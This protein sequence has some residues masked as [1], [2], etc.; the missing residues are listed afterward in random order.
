MAE[1]NYQTQKYT[2]INLSTS[3]VIS[4]FDELKNVWEEK[5]TA[6]AEGGLLALS[7]FEH[8][9]LL[10][11]LRLVRRWR[12]A[13]EADRKNSDV[14]KTVVTEAIS[15]I[16]ESGLLVTLTQV[17]QTLSKT[18]IG[19]ALEELWEI[20][21]LALLHTPDLVEH[22]YFVVSGKFEDSDE[23]DPGKAIDGWGTRKYKDQ[24]QLLEKFKSHVRW[25][26]VPNPKE[27]LTTELEALGRD[28]DTKTIISRWLGYL[29]QLG[30]GLSPEAASTL[31]WRELT[32]DASLKAF[33]TT[34]ARIFSRSQYLLQTIRYAIAGH[35]KLS[36]TDELSQLQDL[37][38]SN[39]I[40]LLSGS[41]GSGK[42]ALC[43]IGIQE[44][45]QDYTCLFLSPDDIAIFEDNSEAVLSKDLRRFDELLTARIIN[46]TIVFVDDV[47]EANEQSLDSLLNLL[48]NTIST[49]TLTNVRFVFVTHPDT[50]Q[51]IQEQ[52]AARFD[53]QPS[54]GMV[55][56]PQLPLEELSSINNLPHSITELIKRAEQFGSAFNFKL[57]D[58]L[59]RKA[60]KEDID[61]SS[62]QTDLD[63][64]NWFWCNQVGNGREV[65]QAHRTLIEI[66]QFLAEKFAPD[67][68]VY[69]C[70]IDPKT[71]PILARRECLRVAEG[72]IALTHRFVGDCA[73][74]HYLL[75]KKRELETED[76][77]EMQS[78]I[79]WSQ[80]MRWFA[81]YIALESDETEIWQEFLQEAIESEHNQ[82]IK[83][84]ID[85][86]ILSGRVKILLDS[87]SKEQFPFL[88]E[89]LCSRLLAIA[90]LPHFEY[91]EIVKN[92]SPG[93]R[94]AFLEENPGTP[95]AHLWIPAWQWILSLEMKILASKNCLVFK[96]AEAWLN[97]GQSAKRLPQRVEIAKFILKLAKY[98]L[99]PDTDREERLWLGDSS[100]AYKCIVFSLMHIPEDASWLLKALAG[101]ELT[102]KTQLAPTT[103]H[104]MF[105]D[106]IGT[107]EF[108]HPKGA[109]GEVN[110]SFRKFMLSNH[111]LYLNGV[112]RVI[113]EL[114]AEILLALTITPPG[115]RFP[116]DKDYSIMNNLGT[117]GSL[118]IDLCT[119]KFLPLLS[120][121][122]NSEE[123]GIEVVST[124][125]QVANN[126]WQ[127][128]CWQKNRTKGTPKTDTNKVEL[129]IDNHR[130]CFQGGRH[131]LYWH[132]KYPWSPNILA[133]FLMTLEGWLYERP[134][135]YSLERSIEL[136]FKKAD[137]VAM[138]GVL[139][140]LAKK[141]MHL[142]TSSLLPLI[143]SLQLLI[144]YE[145]EEIDGGQNYGFDDTRAYSKLLEKE[146]QEL[147]DFHRLPH[148]KES[149]LIIVLHFLVN[150]LFET[151]VIDSIVKDWD[152]YQLN[153]IPEC[154]RSRGLKLRKQFEL[155]NW[156]EEKNAQG[157]PFFRFIGTLPE[158]PKVDKEAESARWKLSQMNFV[159]KC[160]QILDGRLSIEEVSR[161]EL[162]NLLTNEKELS[163]LEEHL[164]EKAFKETI[165]AALALI[166][167]FYDDTQNQQ[168]DEVYK[169]AA[170]DFS[171]FPVSLNYHDRS[172]T[173]DLDICTFM[174]Y[175]APKLLP[176]IEDEN[177]RFKTIF[178]CLIGIKN[179][180]TRIFMNSL[181]KEYGLSNSICH[182]TIQVIPIIAR[183]ISLTRALS[184]TKNKSEIEGKTICFCT[185]H[186]KL[187]LENLV[188][189]LAFL[190]Y[191]QKWYDPI[192]EAWLLLEQQFSEDT[193][194]EVN[195][196]DIFTWTPSNLEPFYQEIPK[197]LKDNID[198]DFLVA[199]F[200]PLIEVVP[201]ENDDKSL[202]LTNEIRENIFLVLLHERARLYEHCRY[203]VTDKNRKC[204]YN[205]KV[206]YQSQEALISALIGYS[207]KVIVSRI[208]HLFSLIK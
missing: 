50:E 177:N 64:L 68:A 135:A 66:S 158:D 122:N 38:L 159:V 11:L 155:S 60:Q 17:K 124:L 113:P 78:N 57:L 10:T 166:L 72:R 59:V 150:G 174:S 39:R 74:F 86:A 110:N 102:P 70:D 198:W 5:Q 2:S 195:I 96:I 162:V 163:S 77:A 53:K 100:A 115:Y 170:E 182:R 189:P 20:F 187:C 119:F 185:L 85:G 203:L 45:F 4:Q 1:A 35:F 157:T 121:L 95:R 49:D 33:Q 130:K 41:S 179:S 106:I 19:K 36:R 56:L 61:T 37:V 65:N 151:K 27:D 58:W 18:A 138:L 84:L 91:A 156:K 171:R 13:S 32:H 173:L 118:D 114:G 69:D 51:Y 42:S 199:A 43:K 120:L 55:K 21:N 206:I 83:L 183:L 75:S 160:K 201:N 44:K 97:W 12:E 47:D 149:L 108:T 167:K 148:R 25:E 146:Y 79:L 7:G 191:L 181:I 145:F 16:A 141:E 134:N 87:F 137:T 165:W 208:N 144:W 54:I 161:E 24:F 112:V 200:T 194:P 129:L 89:Q 188:L 178:R 104:W 164:E 105:E 99:F 81:L 184:N 92:L 126:Y 136:V 125:C 26:I 6:R 172:H 80:P 140:S 14:I 154:N 76:L 107:L 109:K 82:L 93:V 90:T 71:L 30:S 147:L 62:F 52:I 15:D 123:L 193:L 29:L 3:A 204:D 22:L 196:I 88:L 34:L 98:I 31:V 127:K 28:E 132:R 8:Q 197:Y 192:E 101:L 142:L 46:N 131:S 94:I 186:F 139:V 103:Q 111:G 73:R 153:L 202:K 63:L 152:N 190:I 176:N 133:C 175:A 48:Q 128:N 207:S 67:V 9:F 205:D 180:N 116:I 143:S 169:N 23:N 117:T 168:L 40:T